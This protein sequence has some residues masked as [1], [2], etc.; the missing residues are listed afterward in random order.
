MDLK[1]WTP[2]TA[3]PSNHIESKSGF[4][5]Q[6]NLFSKMAAKY[7]GLKNSSG[8]LPFV[9]AC[10]W[11]KPR[12]QCGDREPPP[13]DIRNLAVDFAAMTIVAMVM[14]GVWM[15]GS[16]GAEYV[17]LLEPRL[18]AIT[19]LLEYDVQVRRDRDGDVGD[20]MW[21]VGDE[22]GATDMDMCMCMTSTGQVHVHV[23]VRM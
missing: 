7:L 19:S 6:E 2:V 5:P 10:S 16:C 11:G 3:N 21:R 22:D 9:D 17:E 1:T 8:M 23:H 12:E 20:Q 13:E 15:F 14:D 18:R 4:D